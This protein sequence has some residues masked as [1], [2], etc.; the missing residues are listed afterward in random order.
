MDAVSVDEKKTE[1]SLDNNELLILYSALN[2]VC[3]GISVP[4]FETRIGASKETAFTLLN[5]LGRILDKVRL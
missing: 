1:L 3:N 4:E 5:D 2:E